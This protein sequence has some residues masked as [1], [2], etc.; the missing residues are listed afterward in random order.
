[1][2]LQIILKEAAGMPAIGEE[3][4]RAH[5]K[6]K[7]LR[8]LYFLYGP[9]SYLK[10]YYADKLAEAAGSEVEKINGDGFD[11]GD[12][13]RRSDMP[14]FSG[15]GRCFCI[16]DLDFEKL[17]KADFDVMKAFL[18]DPPEQNV[19]IFRF[20]SVELDYKRSAKIKQVISAANKGGCTL[21]LEHRKGLSLAKVL[22]ARASKQKRTLTSAD[23]NYMIQ[24]C[25][26]D[27]QLLLGEVDKLCIYC[28]GM[29]T[30]EAIDELCSVTVSASVYDI[31]SAALSGDISRAVKIY[32]QLR[33]GQTENIAILAVISGTLADIYRAR[34]AEN[35]GVS[36]AAAA[37]DMGYGNMAWKLK[38]AF[39]QARRI[40]MEKL[41]RCIEL[42]ADADADLKGSP[43]DADIVME[44][45]LV[46]LAQ[47]ARRV[48][49]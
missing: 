22:C 34:A 18:A 9:D 43:C 42:V 19:T 23:A 38:N 21:L 2:T 44:R 10:Q 30:R 47:C 14:D 1:M 25:G 40:S 35:A 24:R 45:L 8:P 27:M 28:D 33:Y 39:S 48:T 4:V 6:S 36:A 37:S 20:E 16:S 13:L 17:P 15:G 29:I 5:I 11:A 12:F 46:M 32:R 26:D 49:A 31:T 3:N 7:S 41:R